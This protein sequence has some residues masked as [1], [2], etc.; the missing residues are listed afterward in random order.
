MIM[1]NVGA[2]S[3]LRK[4]EEAEE[5]LFAKTVQLYGVDYKALCVAQ[6]IVSG[7]NHCF[8]CVAT[9]VVPKAVPYNVLITIYSPLEGE[10]VVT[11]IKKVDIL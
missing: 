10:S 1:N 5:T 3:S 8:L 11:E 7:V 2:Y 9:A 4:I 6:Q